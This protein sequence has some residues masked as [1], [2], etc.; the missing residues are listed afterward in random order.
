M[1]YRT[2][3]L[4]T[5]SIKGPASQVITVSPDE[6]L[7]FVVGPGAGVGLNDSQRDV[8]KVMGRGLN[9]HRSGQQRR[10]PSNGGLLLSSLES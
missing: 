5:A 9:G 1:H 4:R 6:L 8:T 2:S 10:P 7:V 3:E